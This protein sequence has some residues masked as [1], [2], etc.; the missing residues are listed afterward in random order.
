MKHTKLLVV[1]LVSMLGLVGCNRGGE[2][3]TDETVHVEKVDLNKSAIKLQVGGHVQLTAKI[4]PENA[5]V[6][7]VTYSSSNTAVATV[8]TEGLVTAVGVGPATITVTTADGSKTATCNIEVLEHFEELEIDS[9][10]GPAFIN[11]FKAN[12]TRLDD[13][14]TIQVNPNPAK[15]QYYKNE[16]G[17]IDTYKVGSVNPFKFETTAVAFDSAEVESHLNNPQTTVE[18]YVKQDGSYSKVDNLSTYVNVNLSHNEFDFTEAANGKQFKLKIAIDSAAYSEVS[19]LCQPVEFEFEVFDGYNVYS[20]EELSLFDNRSIHNVNC[21]HSPA[22]PWGAFKDANATLREYKNTELKGM[23]LHANM[24]ILNEDIPES[25]KYTEAEVDAYDQ[26]HAGSIQAWID[27]VNHSDDN[28]TVSKENLVGSFRD[29]QSVFYRVTNGESFRFE[30]NY[31]TI[32]A[33]KV[34][35]VTFFNK[36]YQNGT[37]H[38]YGE[39]SLMIPPDGSH[40]SMFG[41]NG[42]EEGQDGATGISRGG[43]NYLNNVTLIGNGKNVSSELYLGGLI[44]Y[45]IDATELN[46]KNVISSDTFITFMTKSNVD[47]LNK[48]EPLPATDSEEDIAAFEQLQP[49]ETSLRVDRYKSFDSY[50]SMFYSWGTRKN[51]FTNSFLKGA[52]GPLF[53]L[54][55]VNANVRGGEAGKEDWEKEFHGF[56]PQVDATNVYLENWITG[57]EPWFSTKNASSF[58][59]QIALMGSLNGPIGGSAAGLYTNEQVPAEYKQLLT[60]TTR[61][62]AD[63][64]DLA[65]VEFI[66][67]I[68]IDICAADFIGNNADGKGSSLRGQFN[69]NNTLNT[70]YPNTYSLNM[71]S[72]VPGATDLP[73]AYTGSQLFRTAYMAGGTMGMILESQNG[74]SLMVG[75][76]DAMFFN[77][78]DHNVY[79][80]QNTAAYQTMAGQLNAGFKAGI[81][82][83]GGSGAF[84]YLYPNGLFRTDM[85]IANATMEV[86]EQ[87]IPTGMLSMLSMDSGNYVSLYLKTGDGTTEFMGAILGTVPFAQAGLLPQA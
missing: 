36:G 18:L 11:T 74:G 41:F 29:Y 83:A 55:E 43:Q 7:D 22:D 80:L 10:A 81:D 61:K 54:D 16:Q 87:V 57:Q 86:G 73:T 76:D 13:I 3:P 79:P 64:P 27:R 12:T 44:M 39:D 72:I 84:D 49:G 24:N 46:C 50:N 70:E 33:S 15:N 34:K 52:G 37:L 30:G 56:V 66:N 42:I 6:K 4:T 71:S 45:K 75:S 53:L 31:F 19:T 48:K 69:I 26:A 65:N 58:A 78:A 63:N 77:M 32:D 2:T 25:M 59:T 5:T 51:V 82:A 38:F 23:A 21:E 8:S 20:K 40:A 1:A 47:Y 17:G 85:T 62:Y 60:T 68:A 14:E 35:Q 28:V 67:L 9:L